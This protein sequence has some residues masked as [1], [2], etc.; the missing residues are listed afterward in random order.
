[1]LI[2][3]VRSKKETDN[4]GLDTVELIMGW[5]E[6]LDIEM[7][8]SDAAVIRT[9][10]EVIDYFYKKMKREGQED[11]GSL[12]IRAFMRIRKAFRDRGIAEHIELNTKVS[13]LLT[14]EKKRDQL[15][16]IIQSLEFKPWGQLPFGLQIICMRVVDLVTVA[17]I[18][19]YRQL[20]VE[21]LNWS[22]GQIGEV[23]RA[24]MY[25]QLNLRRFSN[26]AEIV[27]DLGLD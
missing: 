10:G 26:D 16:S 1:M 5:E 3:Y 2:L 21:N 8:E 7:P 27:R 6:A 4:M 12:T 18:S 9:T 19:D 13:S 14:G 20:R 15:N 22:R 24:V 11:E 17:V 23:V 25:H